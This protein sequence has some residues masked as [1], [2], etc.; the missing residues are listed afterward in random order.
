MGLP[1]P[2]MGLFNLLQFGKI[3]EEEQTVAEIVQGTYYDGFDFIHF[4]SQSMSVIVIELIVRLG[5]AI[6]RI[7]EQRPVLGA[8]LEEGIDNGLK[9]YGRDISNLTEM[10]YLGRLFHLF[11]FKDVPEEQIKTSGY[12]IDSI[13]A[14]VWCLIT[15]DSYKECM[16]KAVNLGDDTDTVA[17]IAGGLAGLYYG[18]EEIPKDWLAVIKKREWI[19]GMCEGLE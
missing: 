16:L 12:V 11:E 18:Y 9:Y 3:G 10:A 19:E 17:A 5:Y 6:K 13:E 14:A 15:T 4:C 2:L 8:L 1:A 7:K